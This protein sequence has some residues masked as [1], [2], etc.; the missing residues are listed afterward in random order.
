MRSCS[1]VDKHRILGKNWCV[2]LKITSLILYCDPK[3]RRVLLPV[4]PT[5][6]RSSCPC[7]APSKPKG[8]KGWV[9]DLT[10]SWVTFTLTRRPHY[11]I[12]IHRQ[13]RRLAM[14]GSRVV[15]QLGPSG[16]LG[17]ECS[18]LTPS[19][20]PAVKRICRNSCFLSDRIEAPRRSSHSVQKACGWR[21]KGDPPV[22]LVKVYQLVPIVTRT[23]GT[24][25][26]LYK[27]HSGIKWWSPEQLEPR[28]PQIVNTG[29][30]QPTLCCMGLSKWLCELAA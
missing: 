29:R 28:T 1:G 14:N 19:L 30:H 13:C 24:Q 7:W 26:G 23:P 3:G 25:V 4:P 10:N 6:G 22:R 2:H 21:P 20:R 16:R 5:V 15:L 17:L 18:Q 11:S 12:V 9:A 8:P 27:V